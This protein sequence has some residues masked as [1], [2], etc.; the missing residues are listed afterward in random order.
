MLI[1]FAGGAQNIKQKQKD[2][3]NGDGTAPKKSGFKGLGSL[4]R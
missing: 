4:V 3:Q 1:G 2:S